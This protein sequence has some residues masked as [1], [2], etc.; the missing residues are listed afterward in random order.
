ML[1]ATR[2]SALALW[3]AKWV[4]SQLES[5]HPGLQVGLVIIKTRG[6]R[7]LDVP[8]AKVGGKGLFVKE[9]EEALLDG[10]ADLAV[11][12]MKDL[13]ADFP[14]GLKLGAVL[15]RA[16][17]RDVLL[18][19]NHDS[20]AG[21]PQ[22][23]SVGSSSLRRQSQLLALR[24]DLKIRSLRGN[25]NTRISKLKAGEFDAIVL[26]A[27]GVERLAMTQHVVAYLDPL[28]IIPANGQGA[29]GIEL[30][31]DDTTTARFIRP[32]N[33]LPTWIC[34]AAERALLAT[35]EGG[36][37]VPI[38]GHAHFRGEEELHLLGRVAA[39]DGTKQ[40]TA[41]RTGPPTAPEALGRQLARDL[42]AKG[43]DRILAEVLAL[44]QIPE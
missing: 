24:P 4:Q 25:V 39:I 23:A 31:N 3:Q 17:P 21:L 41:T 30:R 6:D 8:L 33:H 38:A 37:Q 34:V 14:P 27:A 11:H 19:V 43:A 16:D 32:L 9:L 42:I 26:A 18:S 10:R 28:K 7:I 15:E 1:I 36:C 44:S 5:A 35:L 12:S 13:P 40:I 22:G 29:V 2:G 20:L